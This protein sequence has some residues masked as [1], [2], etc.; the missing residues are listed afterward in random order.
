VQCDRGAAQLSLNGANTDMSLQTLGD[1]TTSRLMVV[2]EALR[3]RRVS[4]QVRSYQWNEPVDNSTLLLD[5]WFLDL[6]LTPRPRAARGRFTQKWRQD[7]YEP[8]GDVIFIPPHLELRSSHGAGRQMSLSLLLVPDLF[9]LCVDD[10]DEAS[11]TEALHVSDPG[12]RRTLWRLGAEVSTN[13]IESAALIEAGALALTGQI[14]GRLR[15]LRGPRGAK[16]GG[17]TPFRRRLI[18]ER[19]RADLPPPKI[20][21]LAT[22][23]CLSERQLAR[24][25]RAECGESLGVYLANLT[26]RRAWSL[27]SETERPIGSIAQ[28]LGFASGTSFAEAFRKSTGCRPS[29]V[30]RLRSRWG[31]QALPK[32]RTQIAYGNPPDVDQSSL[33]ASGN[34]LTPA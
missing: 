8:I 26:L 27:L 10:F 33:A 16:R 9:D 21:D 12:I 13:R 28:T 14:G 5:H 3:T 34:I 11:L 1:K 18:D 4:V 30:R 23:C 2:H 22:I 24:A 25:F 29:D 20:S 32:P 6:S 19:V 15:E 7:R 31:D 17:L